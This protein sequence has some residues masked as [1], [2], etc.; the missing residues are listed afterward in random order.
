MNKMPD[1][2]VL[3]KLA[4]LANIRNSP[5]RQI[6]KS[7]IEA[8]IEVAHTGAAFVFIDVRKLKTAKKIGCL[9]RELK[10]ALETSDKEHLAHFPSFAR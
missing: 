6:F 4:E 8:G 9:A 3:A 2:K 1:A 5:L 7:R 10:R